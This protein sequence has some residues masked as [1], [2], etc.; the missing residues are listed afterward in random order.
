MNATVRAYLIK[1]LATL[2]DEITKK[3]AEMGPEPT[4]SQD[5]NMHWLIGRYDEAKLTMSMLDRYTEHT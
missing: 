5:I 1:R 4:R 2:N 3:M